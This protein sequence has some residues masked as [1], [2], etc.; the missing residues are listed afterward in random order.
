[1]GGNGSISR[2]SWLLMSIPRADGGK[3]AS[4]FLS[5]GEKGRNRP[6]LSLER[7]R[8]VGST[9]PSGRLGEEVKSRGNLAEKRNP[10]TGLQGLRPNNPEEVRGTAACRFQAK[11]TI[12]PSSMCAAAQH[13]HHTCT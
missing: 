2:S 1:M 10:D 5:T 7:K 13:E 6:T 9:R 4:F 8:R 12:L 11:R 3:L